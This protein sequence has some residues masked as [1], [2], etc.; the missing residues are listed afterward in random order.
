M[1]REFAIRAADHIGVKAC[2]GDPLRLATTFAFPGNLVC[3]LSA[4][5]A[6]RPMRSAIVAKGGFTL[7][8]RNFARRVDWRDQINS[9]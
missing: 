1:L 7:C 6:S 2:A 5:A 4:E 8:L 3:G 9:D